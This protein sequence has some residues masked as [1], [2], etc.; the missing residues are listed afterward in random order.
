ML[1]TFTGF[2][3]AN[4][5]RHFAF[6]CL[7]ANKIRT[8]VTVCADL[9]LARKHNIMMQDLPLLCLRLLEKRGDDQSPT[10][11]IF[12]EANMEAVETAAASLVAARKQNR[13]VPAPGSVGQAWRQ[14][15]V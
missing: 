6:D 3:Q 13:R 4:S 12:T 7:A 10:S 2:R 15:Q 8:Q 1:F 5:V 11:L 14:P 9:A